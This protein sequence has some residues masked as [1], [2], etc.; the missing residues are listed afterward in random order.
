MSGTNVSKGMN[1]YP[2]INWVLLAADGYIRHMF[3]YFFLIKHVKNNL[4]SYILDVKHE[5][6]PKIYLNLCRFG[7]LIYTVKV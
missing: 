6:K 7:E 5:W 4:F 1:L 3:I 2:S